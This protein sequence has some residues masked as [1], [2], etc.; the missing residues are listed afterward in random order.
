LCACGGGVQEEKGVLWYR[1]TKGKQ[2]LLVVCVIVITAAAVAL[3]L[4]LLSMLLLMVV[5]ARKTCNYR[6]RPRGQSV[7]K[8]PPRTV[9]CS[10]VAGRA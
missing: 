1:K 7:R 9:G 6:R 5:A 10:F 2:S 8:G 4:L 3:V